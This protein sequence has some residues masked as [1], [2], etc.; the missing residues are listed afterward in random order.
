MGSLYLQSGEYA[1]YGLPAGTTAAQVQAASALL[2]AYLK[3]PEGLVWTAGAGGLPCF[4]AGLTPQF[5]FTA[6]G[7]VAPGASVVV[8]VAGF[9]LTPDLV[10]EV[11]VLD[12]TDLTKAEACVVAGVGAGSVT[13]QSV[14]YAH[15]AGPNLDA[16]L[17]IFEERGLPSNRSITR[18]ARSPSPAWYRCRAAT[19]TAAA[20]SSRR[21]SS[22][23]RAC[24]PPS[25]SSAAR[26]HGR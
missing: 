13:L 8:P 5:T 2:D 22:P 18:V 19:P 16:G 21:A 9:M 12:R 3:R 26:P 17:A 24:W 4:M 1:A 15:A 10:G 23:S 20:A 7:A 14:S 25:R 6:A 11:L